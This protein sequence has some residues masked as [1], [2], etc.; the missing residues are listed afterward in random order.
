MIILIILL[1]AATL[2]TAAASAAAAG[3]SA[4]AASASAGVAGR[5][6]AAAAAAAA[7]AHSIS[8][9]KGDKGDKGDQGDQ[10]KPGEPSNFISRSP[11][12]KSCEQYFI[13]PELS[14]DL[15]GYVENAT[16]ST[17]STSTLLS[18]KN[19]NNTTTNLNDKTNFSNL[20]VSNSSI[21]LSSLHISGRSTLNNINIMPII[22]GN[23]NVNGTATIIDTV[24]NNTSFNSF[25][26]LS[27][28]VVKSH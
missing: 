17:F 9:Q 5:S 3:A 14:K 21:L 7:A 2:S 25:S 11:L 4:S 16:F 23:L 8:L 19:L 20:F 13:Y 10:G 12:K 24:V 22:M 27:C 1:P 6:A 28:I 18:I 26:V 15:S